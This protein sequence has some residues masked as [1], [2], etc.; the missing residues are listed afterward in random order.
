[1]PAHP[2]PE[3]IPSAPLSKKEREKD[4]KKS[5][6]ASAMAS[7]ASTP[8]PSGPEA[9]LV[10]PAGTYTT[11]PGLASEPP[12]LVQAEKLETALKA[13]AKA[14]DE[15]GELIDAAVSEL[16]L[17]SK[18]SERFA[19]DLASLRG[20]ELWA[21]VPKPDFGRSV[22]AGGRARDVVIPYALDEAP[23]ALHSRSLAAFDLDPARPEMVFGARSF[24]RLRFLLRRG[25]DAPT[26]S[27]S[28]YDQSVE[29]GEDLC[30]VMRAA[31]IE[32]LDEDL[33]SELRAEAARVDGALVEP[34]SFTVKV[35]R[36]KLTIEL[37]DTRAPPSKP[38]SHLADML[39]GVARLNMLYAY[40]RRKTRLVNGSGPQHPPSLVTLLSLI[41]VM[42][43]L[44]SIRPALERIHETLLAAGLSAHLAERHA[45]ADP[46][47]S[48]ALMTGR[49]KY[50]VLGVVFT[51]DVAG[52]RNDDP[53]GPSIFVGGGISN[54][55]GPSTDGSGGRGF[56]SVNLTAPASVTVVVPGTS[57]PVKDL[58]AL[59]GIIAE[60]VASQLSPL[61][62]RGV[63]GEAGAFYDEL[64]RCIVLGDRGPVS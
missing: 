13:R 39:L 43:A 51:L 8:L 32:T 40:K 16:E 33:F 27:S 34:R 12:V 59:P 48:E 47:V 7:V 62:Y 15:C 10:L 49:A 46:S 29:E 20:S 24:Q 1:M 23:P 4:K 28:V 5:L 30:A 19:A 52:S 57:F 38:E 64:E 31:Q 9:E 54:H 58:E 55:H 41:Q 14:L 17:M 35:G 18:A 6:A 3:P 37:Y 25:N 50:D 61:L 53:E 21:I 26:Y 2:P 42:S 63:K 22:Q 56:L 36:D 44:S 45:T 60:H 11:T